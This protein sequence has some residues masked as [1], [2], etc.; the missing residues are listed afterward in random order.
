MKVKIKKTSIT[1]LVLLAIFFIVFFIALNCVYSKSKDTSAKKTTN[2]QSNNISKSTDKIVKIKDA[3][4]SVCSVPSSYKKEAKKQGELLTFSYKAKMTDKSKRIVDKKATIYLPHG[5]NDKNKYDIIYLCHGYGANENTFLGSPDNPREFKNILDNMI[6]NGEIKPVIVVT[7]TYIDNYSNYYDKLDGMTDEIVNDLIPAVEG[8][9]S[10]YAKNTSHDEII[11]S[12]NHRA[13]GGFSMGGCT[14]WRAFRRHLD[15]FKYYMP[16]SMPMYYYEPGYNKLQNDKTAPTLAEAAANSGYKPED[17]AIY[18]ASGDKDF[19][20]E[21]TKQV[22]EKLKEYPDQF[23]YTTTNFSDGNL[24]FTTFSGYH[25]YYFSNPYMYNGL[26]RF[27]R[28]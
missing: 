20:N 19:M 28:E 14:T 25:R 13:I 12:R 8:K 7:P 3:P 17:Y 21:A 5:Y 23:K 15:C 11:K 18:A 27:F 6:E 10:T 26:R 22:V 2:N 1:M 4:K 9:Y 24:M 16:M